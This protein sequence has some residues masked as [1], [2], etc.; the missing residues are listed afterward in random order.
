MDN[1]CI[2]CGT[3]LDPTTDCGCGCDGETMALQKK[4]ITRLRRERDD[5]HKDRD[6]VLKDQMPW[7]EMAEAVYPDNE[8]DFGDALAMIIK[9]RIE[10]RRDLAAANGMLEWINKEVM[11]FVMAINDAGEHRTDGYWMIDS[12][13]ADGGPPSDLEDIRDE[14]NQYISRRKGGA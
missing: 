9:E 14:L 12:V 10:D 7:M 6:R 2:Y 11:P 5:W 8:Y 3:P 4:T 1:P 13:F